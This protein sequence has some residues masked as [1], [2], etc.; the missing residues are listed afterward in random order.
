MYLK[1]YDWMLQSK[2][3]SGTNEKVYA[4]IY[5]LSQNNQGFWGNTT[6]LAN[7]LGISVRSTE[8]A[9]KYLTQINAIERIN[10]HLRTSQSWEKQQKQ[11]L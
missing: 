6:Y 2:D 3:L 11:K 7:T 10:G 1:I 8:Q 9:L 5:Q 4:L